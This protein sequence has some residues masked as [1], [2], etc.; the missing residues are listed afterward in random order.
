MQNQQMMMMQMLQG[1]AAGQKSKHVG[2]QRVEMKNKKYVA[3]TAE[4]NNQEAE[5]K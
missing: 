1:M 5:T 3:S 2:F 4:D